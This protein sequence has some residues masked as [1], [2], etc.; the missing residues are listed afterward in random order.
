MPRGAEEQSGATPPAMRPRQF[1]GGFQWRMPSLE[2]KPKEDSEE[3]P[4]AEANKPDV[5]DSA[6]AR[7]AEQERKDAVWARVAKAQADAKAKAAAQAQKDPDADNQLPVFRVIKKL[8]HPEARNDEERAYAAMLKEGVKGPIRVRLA[9]RATLWLPSGY[10]Y[11]DAERAR[12]VMDGEAGLT[13]PNNQGVILPETRTPT[14]MAYVDL[15]D[16]GYVADE[17]AK[18]MNAASLLLGLKT[19]VGNQNAERSHY[20]V[21]PLTIDRWIKTPQ[22]AAAKHDVDACVSAVDASAADPGGRLVNCFSYALGRRGAV[23]ILVT[24]EESNLAAFEHEASGLTEHITYDQGRAYRDYVAG[25]DA[26]AEYGAAE[27]VGGVVGLKSIVA[28]AAA[29]GAGK[30]Q[31]LFLTR[32]LSYWEEIL[33]ALIVVVLAVRWLQENRSEEQEEEED[34]RATPRVS[35]FRHAS[36]RLGATIRGLF[37]TEEVVQPGAAK[38]VAAGA[39]KQGAEQNAKS[40]A[41]EKKSLVAALRETAAKLPLPMLRKA[42]KDAAAPPVGEADEKI[43]GTPAAVA[44]SAPAVKRAGWREKIAALPVLAKFAKSS[45]PA[46][47]AAA[48]AATTPAS[49]GRRGAE[50]E[51]SAVEPVAENVG[52]SANK[53]SKLASIMRKKAEEPAAP[54][55]VSRVATKREAAPLQ[56]AIAAPAPAASA[57]PKPAPAATAAPEPA[58]APRPEPALSTSVADILDLVE[59]GD[60]QASTIARE[61]LQQ[62]HG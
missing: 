40:A 5:D 38:Q 45:A 32:V 26:V 17:N 52:A 47:A 7:K 14:W 48:T 55:A 22:Y 37:E 53:L 36:S 12:D 59:P 30:N 49:K 19:S 2:A 28:V 3:K 60:A 50:V 21:A 15:L 61:A 24:G 4:A 25:Q 13:D 10:V 54:V 62:A 33:T 6:A 44:S 56:P 9:D 23:K 1:S 8:M 39:A 11:I 31:E 16:D 29:A 41:A 34:L 18:N 57:A 27:L 42:A 51:T 58:R 20:G 35:F 46:A 43:E